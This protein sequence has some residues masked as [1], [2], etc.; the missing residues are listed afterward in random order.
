MCFAGTNKSEPGL[1][2]PG[3]YGDGSNRNVSRSES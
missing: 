3:H 2:A 1:R